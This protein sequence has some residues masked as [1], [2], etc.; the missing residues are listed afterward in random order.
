MK[1]A[2][3]IHIIT[4]YFLPV[5][6][7]IEINILETYSRL[8]KKGWTIHVHTSK[9]TYTQKNILPNYELIR[10]LHVHRYAYHW[11]GFLPRFDTEKTA[12]V[13]IHNFDVFPHILLFS[14]YLRKRIFASK[15]F[16][17]F[18]TPHG[19]FTPEWSI[20]TPIQRFIKKLYHDTIGL[21]FINNLVDGVRAVS[22][23]EREQL[24]SRGVKRSLIH[25]I[26]NGLEDEAFEDADKHA[27]PKIKS[28]VKGYGRYIFGNARIYQIKNQE[29]IIRALVHLPEDIIFVN[30]GTI[31][32]TVGN[33]TGSDAYYKRLLLLARTLGV[34]HRVVFP[35]VITGTDKYYLYKHALCFVHMAIWESF[36]NVV[37]EALSQGLICVVA[38]NTALPYLVAHDKNGFL[39][40]TYDDKKLAHTID[41]IIDPENRTTMKNIQSHNLAQY[42]KNSWQHVSEQLG[43]A[44]GRLTT[45]E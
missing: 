3:V 2:R 45:Y 15:N 37:H 25:L 9:D 38:N 36:C 10:G 19:G 21:W 30:I 13:A 12:V 4:K 32:S 11:Y 27:S 24:T 28:L 18:L 17:L 26:P 34:D 1:N 39:V 33:Q 44:L 31:G 22:S 43:R 6:A 35:G 5:T 41:M 20:F 29:T 7:G 8:V 42:R 40:D 16:I 23:W 14:N